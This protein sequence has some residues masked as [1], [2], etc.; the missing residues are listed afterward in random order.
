MCVCV[1]VCVCASGGF[2]CVFLVLPGVVRAPD[3]LEI[4]W[5]DAS[6]AGVIVKMHGQLRGEFLMAALEW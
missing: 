2:R 6:G 3:T 5:M 1:C 4:D